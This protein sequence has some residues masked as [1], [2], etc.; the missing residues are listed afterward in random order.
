MP[1]GGR[2]PGIR[3][4]GRK[5]MPDNERPVRYTFRLKPDV[6]KWLKESP[7]NQQAAREAITLLLPKP[8]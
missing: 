3:F 4:G 5:P 2:K 6:V 1:K 8:N 7:D